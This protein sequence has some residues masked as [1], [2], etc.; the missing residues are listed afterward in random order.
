MLI[1]LL[2]ERQILREIYYIFDKWSHHPKA[3][4]GL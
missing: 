2:I 4:F 1:G 3:K